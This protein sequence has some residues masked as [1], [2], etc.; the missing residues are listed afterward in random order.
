LALPS[1]EAVQIALRTQQLI[2]YETGVTETVDPLA[3]SYYVESLTEA[4][5]S[6]AENYLKKINDMG[7]MIPAIESGYVQGEIANSA[8]EYQKKVESKERTVVGLNQFQVEEPPLR[9]L[10]KVEKTVGELQEKKLK[11]LRSERSAQ[12]V[13]TALE[14]VRKAAK[15]KDNLMPMILDAVKAEATIGEI[16]DVLRGVFGEYTGT[17]SF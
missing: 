16:C 10:L 5:V 4:I 15:T 9:G 6:Q 8:Y 12:S 17:T 2:A 7:G 1:E 3:G 13:K 11:A 14:D